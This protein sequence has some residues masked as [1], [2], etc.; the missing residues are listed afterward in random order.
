MMHFISEPLAAQRSIPRQMITNR[1]LRLD[2]FFCMIVA[3]F[4]RM[5]QSLRTDC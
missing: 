4:E 3:G 5:S 1:F 2:H